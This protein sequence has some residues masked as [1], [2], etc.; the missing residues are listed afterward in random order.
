M[1]ISDW[2]SDVFSSDLP[3]ARHSRRRSGSFDVILDQPLLGLRYGLLDGMQLLGDVE[4]GSPIFDHGDD[5]AQV[6]L[7]ALQPVDDLRVTCRNMGFRHLSFLYSPR[8]DKLRV[9]K[10]Y[11]RTRC[12]LVTGVQTCSLPI[13]LRPAIRGVG[14]AVSM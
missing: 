1:R 12:A 14:Q 13:S 4:A 2:S 8:S 5:A 7:R 3:A 10:E 11:V 6:P 9:G